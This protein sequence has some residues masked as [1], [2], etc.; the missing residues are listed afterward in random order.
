MPF[1][2][3][4]A[5][6]AQQRCSGP[7]EVYHLAAGAQPGAAVAIVRLSGPEAVFVAQRVFRP[8]GSSRRGAGK[9]QAIWQPETHRVY[10]GQL[11]DE[12]GGVLDE[13]LALACL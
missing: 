3:A 12:A 2:V 6:Q 5:Q 8:S 4:N 9:A 7:L 13:V 10:H 1:G 11:V